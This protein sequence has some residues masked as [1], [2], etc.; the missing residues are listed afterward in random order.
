MGRLTA[1]DAAAIRA[2]RDAG[3]TFRAIGAEFGITPSHAKAVCDGRVHRPRPE[4]VPTVA[5]ARAKLDAAIE[6][7]RAAVEAEAKGRPE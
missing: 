7:F 4:G 5:E 6:V 2:R 3:A 1:E